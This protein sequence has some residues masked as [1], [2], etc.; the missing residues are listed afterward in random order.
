MENQD[1]LSDSLEQPMSVGNWLITI[2]LMAIPIVNVV[3]L[4]IWAF[5]SNTNVSK[6]NWAKATLILFVILFCL[7][8]LFWGSI[9]AMFPN[10]I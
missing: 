8:F 4:F 6:A 5:G 1:Y 3:L 2:L 10:Q 9:F 7:G